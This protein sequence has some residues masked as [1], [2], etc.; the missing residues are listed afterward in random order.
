M[1]I[2]ETYGNDSSKEPMC[3]H[4]LMIDVNGDK[5][6]SAI[7]GSINFKIDMNI[8]Q[9]NVAMMPL[10]AVAMCGIDPCPMWS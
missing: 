4:V 7:L 5:L 9:P 1:D 2:I 10:P 3:P 8:F 6:S